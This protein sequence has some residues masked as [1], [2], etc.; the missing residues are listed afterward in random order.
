MT[1]SPEYPVWHVQKKDPL[2]L[3]QLASAWQL[4]APEVHSSISTKGWTKIKFFLAEVYVAAKIIFSQGTSHGYFP[5]IF[6]P[7]I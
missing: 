2:V 5:A 7:G 1:P 4:C 3:E 6:L